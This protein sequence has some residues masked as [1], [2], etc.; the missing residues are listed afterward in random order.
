[1]LRRLIAPVALVFALSACAPAPAPTGAGAPAPPTP[2]AVPTPAPTAAVDVPI[3][4]STL[5]PVREAVPPVRVQIGAAGIDIEVIPVGVE[6]GGFMELPENPAIAGWYRFGS[7]PWSPDG[8]TVISAH[9][10]AP[11]Y[12]IGPFAELRG[13]APGSEVTVLGGDGAAAVYDVVSVTYYPKQDLP[14]DDIF[15]RVGTRAL[16]LITCGGA[17]D[18]STGRYA[19]NVVVV[20]A[21]R[22]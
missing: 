2:S 5:A 22:V 11:E 15:A 13:L 1:M 10:D 8:N 4:Q 14:T 12:P 3:A 9:I 17:F 18:S 16:V 20:A 19:D 7:D 6:A 21:P